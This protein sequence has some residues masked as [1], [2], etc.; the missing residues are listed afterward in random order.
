VKTTTSS[1]ANAIMAI[2]EKEEEE[3]AISFRWCTVVACAEKMVVEICGYIGEKLWIF[4]IF[5]RHG[6]NQWVIE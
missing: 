3:E 2:E 5:A 1:T 6:P 4:H